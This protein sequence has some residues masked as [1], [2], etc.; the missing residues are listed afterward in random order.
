MQRMLKIYWVTIKTVV[1][2]WIEY[3]SSNVQNLNPYI[4]F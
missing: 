4:N 2:K 1:A 3:I